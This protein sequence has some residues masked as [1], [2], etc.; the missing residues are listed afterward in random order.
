MTD[1]PR[2]TEPA[3]WAEFQQLSDE[4]HKL[5]RQRSEAEE[6]ESTA[7]ATYRGFVRLPVAVRI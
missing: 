7:P 1:S 3:L 5:A 6:G 4:V 2:G